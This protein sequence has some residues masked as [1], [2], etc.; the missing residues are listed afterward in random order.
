MI[1]KSKKR[2]KGSIT[3]ED[4]STVLQ[5][6]S[7]NTVLALM[8]EVAHVAGDK[9]D[10][11][12]LVKNTATGISG[13]RE[14]QMLWRHLAYGQTLIDQFDNDAN[15]MDDDSDLEYELEAFPAI[16]RE[17]SAEAAAC[18]KVL[19]ASACPKDSD[20]PNNSNIEA[21]LTINI[22]ISK[23]SIAP[24]DSSL[25]ASAMHGTNI[26]IPVFVPK[27][28]LSSGI[29]GEKRPIT[30]TS[31]VT[32]PPRRKR[33]GWST[34][35]DMKLTAAVQ[36]YGERNWANIARGDFKNDRKASELSQRWAN[37]RKKQ[38]N[39][40]VGTSSQNS[41]TQLAAAHRAM[42][43]ALD[44][45]MGEMKATSQISLVGARPLHQVQKPSPSLPDQ[46]L[47]RSGP[48][49]SQL[50]M[51]R[52]P[53]T[54]PTSAPDSMVK[55]AAV[56]A[57]A[58]IATSADASSLIEAAR[59]QNVV[60]ITTGGSS[61][62]KPS[63]T[64]SIKNQLPSNVHF[65]RNGLAKA[66]ISAYSAT[67]P[68]IISRP[69][70]AQQAQGHSIKPAASAIQS[71]QVGPAPVRNVASGVENTIASSE[72]AKT[73]KDAVVS[74]SANE[75]KE[76]VQRN[77]GADQLAELSNQSEEVEK[78]QSSASGNSLKENSRG[79]QASLPFSGPSSQT[80]DGQVALP[81]SEVETSDKK[82]T[83][84]QHARKE[85]N[86]NSSPNGREI[87]DEK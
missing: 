45:P 56:A 86:E 85:I 12:E 10:W 6:Y 34:E 65:I 67:K 51:K 63:T 76:L 68:T 43:L 72:I 78:H 57:G 54:N 55:A 70:E 3:E 21:P 42:S 37:L 31:G 83:D 35:D 75:I 7:V 48:P 39:L 80:Q 84:D 36:K 17:A 87:V 47:G 19:I 18:V 24:S 59:S 62:I 50:P 66:P 5:R 60:H 82:N 61:M 58:R 40:K 38:G 69:G 71:N 16:G 74:S 8:Q 11:N 26:S 22:P 28:P 53:S 9:I 77:K 14:Y 23:P 79:N 29:C 4:I 49:K 73:A 27:L 64:T 2:K 33:R 41:E 46:Q 1:D 20:P 13:A 32:F 30:E 44:M 15:P 81:C 25:L 52:L